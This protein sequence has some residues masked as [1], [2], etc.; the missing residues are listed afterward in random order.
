MYLENEALT[1]E[2]GLTTFCDDGL[3]AP[4]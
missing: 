1:F 2:V 3:V 4:V